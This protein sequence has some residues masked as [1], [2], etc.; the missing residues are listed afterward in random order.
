MKKMRKMTT[1]LLCMLLGG[2]LALNFTGCS[3]KIQAEDLMESIDAKPAAE[4]PADDEFIQASADF[5]VK[6]FQKTVDAEK[7]SLIS[8]LSVMLALAMTANGADT[9]TRSEMEALLGGTIPLEALNQYLYAYVK[10]LP[11][12]EKYKLQIANSIWFREDAEMIEVKPEFLQ[13]NADYYNAA[14]YRSAFDEQTV[15]DINNWVKEKTDGMI[16]QIVD[17]IDLSTMMYLINAIVFDAEWETIYHKN[18]VYSGNFTTYS[19]KTNSVEMMRSDESKYIRDENATGF[20]KNYKNGKYSFAALLPNEN[21]SIGDYIASLSGADLLSMLSRAEPAA[22]AAHLP[23]F[24]YD[25]SLFLNGALKAMGMPAA[26]SGD[27]ADFTRLGNSSAGNLYIGDVL[28]KTFISVNE[29]GTKAGAVTKVEIKAESAMPS[30]YVVKLDR[31][32]VYAI[33]DNSTNLPVF[34]G[35]VSDIGK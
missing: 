35:A 17:Q 28:H 14:A 3:V 18:D 8:P 33:I 25:S 12:D 21:I 26:F 2:I 19:G 16:D 22:V 30:G 15:K 34:L 10:N 9:Q 4:K 11:T 31:P 7:N 20:V 23:K 32:F 24:T 6:L 27:T 29:R 13:I 1:M 5:A